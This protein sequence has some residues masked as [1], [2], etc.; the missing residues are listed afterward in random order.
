MDARRD[1]GDRSRRGGRDRACAVAGGGGSSPGEPALRTFVS[2]VENLLVQSRDGRRAVTATI[3]GFN[4][5]R[6]GPRVAVERL[7]RVQRNRQSLLQ[8]VAALS[9]PGH[10]GAQ[11]SADLLQRAEQRSIS[12]DWHYRDW[13]EKQTSCGPPQKDPDLHKAWVA[14]KG[15]NRIKRQFVAA[16]NPL[17]QLFQLRIWTEYEF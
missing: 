9:V 10:T 6:F 11:S 16:F 1:R 2:R 14:D 12:A 17:A 5:C 8:Q 3:D 15:A 13:L 4:Q 7:N